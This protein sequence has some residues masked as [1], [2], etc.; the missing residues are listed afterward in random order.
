M[1]YLK[2]NC[3]Y[4]S[5]AVPIVPINYQITEPENNLQEENNKNYPRDEINNDD[6]IKEVVN[7]SLPLD[8]KFIDNSCSITQSYSITQCE[9]PKKNTKKTFYKNQI[10]TFEGKFKN[11]KLNGEGKITYS[12]GTIV[13]GYL[14][15]NILNGKG[16]IEVPSTGK[17][18]QG[19]FRNG[20]LNGE[21]SLRNIDGTTSIGTFKD[22]ELHGKGAIL[23]P[24]GGKYEGV[25]IEDILSG[26]G[27][28]THSC[29]RIEEG[30]FE[31]GILHG[32]G[33]IISADGIV[34]EGEFVNGILKTH[35]T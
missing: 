8:K 12:N 30:N 20:K 18:Y 34:T 24:N 27:K 19:E 14:V 23:L 22:N 33:M 9:T 6:K 32:L 25:F 31:N 11:N 17:K 13:K 7:N 10:T 5:S 2:F 21:G 28:V 35:L 16:I 15:D 3:C 26:A 29:G 1:H 4:S